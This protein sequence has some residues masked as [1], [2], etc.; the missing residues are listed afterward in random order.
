MESTETKIDFSE[1]LGEAW[2]VYTLSFG[3]HALIAAG[4]M[5]LI[6]LASLMLLGPDNIFVN[7]KPTTP[8][9]LDAAFGYS[10]LVFFVLMMFVG[11]VQMG[12]LIYRC[13][14]F[15]VG[16][17][18]DYG[19][20][21]TVVLRRL[22]ALLVGGIFV[23]ILVGIGTLLCCIP[24][25]VAWVWLFA[26]MPLIIIDGRGPID[27]PMESIAL[28]V[29]SRWPILFLVLFT[30][31]INIFVQG[32]STVVVLAA[33]STTVHIAT[34]VIGQAITMPLLS[35]I[36]AVTYA[37]LQRRKTGAVSDDVIATFE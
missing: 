1:T 7:P 3:H 2:R 25:L 31:L 32:I 21:L 18:T 17:P 29:G 11:L 15:A 27:A 36:L 35:A 20:A 37:Q 23:G 14:A 22:P 26:T 19:T 12:L 24:G 30:F 34:S 13:H 4:P 8:P 28:T 10:M 33:Q 5:L 9:V 16:Q 6:Y